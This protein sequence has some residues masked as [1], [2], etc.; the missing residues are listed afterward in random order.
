MEK[1][2]ISESSPVYLGISKTTPQSQYFKQYCLHPFMFFTVQPVA[3]VVA[4]TVWMIHK[5]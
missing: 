2:T 5:L 1:K 4:P 3:L